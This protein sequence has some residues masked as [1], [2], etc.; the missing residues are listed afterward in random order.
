MWK[1]QLTSPHKLPVTPICLAL[2]RAWS[3]ICSAFSAC[4]IAAYCVAISPNA[5][6]L[7]FS[8]SMDLAI[9]WAWAKISKALET[10]SQAIA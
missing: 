5:S 2:Q 3:K 1:V 9:A 10:A 8:A 6:A 7:I 4:P